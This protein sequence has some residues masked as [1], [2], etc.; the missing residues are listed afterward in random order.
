MTPTSNLEAYDLFLLGRAAMAER[1]AGLTESI[2]LFSRATA[3]DPGWA[4]AWAG[5]A[6]AQSLV[7]YY[8]AL[9]A[10]VPDSADWASALDAGEAA[11]RRA[12]DLDPRSAAAEVAL[13]NVFRDRWDWDQ[14]EAHYLRALSTPTIRRRIS[15]M[16]MCWRRSVVSRRD[17][18][19]PGAPS[20]SIRRP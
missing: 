18:E 3:L 17:S 14:S 5:L 2:A 8:P 12:L 7:P 9:G 6:M 1:G 20:S 13:G 11:A 10:P 16:P 19:A 4:P 15:S